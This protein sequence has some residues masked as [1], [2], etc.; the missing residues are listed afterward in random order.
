MER[1]SA[2]IKSDNMEIITITDTELLIQTRFDFF[3]GMGHPVEECKEEMQASL[4]R[5]FES[6][7]DKDFVVLGV[8]VN[9]EIVSIGYLTINEIPPN[10]NA[11]NGLAGTL[12]NVL[13]YPQHRGQGYAA[14][15]IEAVKAEARRRNLSFIDLYATEQGTPLYEKTGFIPISYKAMRLKL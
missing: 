2:G 14:A 5:Y 12:L 13:T 1:Q 8:K 10:R 6:R 3:A 9:D 15:L 4:R 11:V 7:T